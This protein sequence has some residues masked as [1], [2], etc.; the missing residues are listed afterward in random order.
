[1]QRRLFLC[2]LPYIYSSIS[3]ANDA[4]WNCEQSK[5]NKEWV[6]S[7]ADKPADS[8]PATTPE[9]VK[10]TATQPAAEPEQQAVEQASPT[11]QPITT[12][13]LPAAPAVVAKPIEP[14]PAQ[15]EAIPPAKPETAVAEPESAESELEE[16]APAVAGKSEPVPIKPASASSQTARSGWTCGSSDS[17][18]G[19]N[20]NLVG[21]DPAGKAQLVAAEPSTF[22]ILTPTFDHKQEQTF[23]TLVSQLQYDPWQNCTVSS[24][25]KPK[26]VPKKHLRETTPLDVKSDYSEVFDNEISS[27]FG[28]VEM[29]RADQH[30]ISNIANYDTVS[31]ALGLQ[32]SV[33]YSEDELAL[34][35]ESALLKLA[36]DQAKIRDVLFI[37][38]GVPL[39]GKA[40]AVY[41]ENKILSRYKDVAYTSCKPGNQDWLIHASELKMN[42]STGK[43]AAKN[44][45]LE[46][47]GAPVF[48]SPYL[49]FPIDDRRL[50]G[51]LAPSFGNT[52]RNGFDVSVPYYW[53]IAPNF[54]AT[55][56][57]RYLSKRGVLLGGEFRYLTEASKGRFGVE[58]MP[59]DTKKDNFSY[60]N[61]L[62]PHYDKARFVG[63]FVN[64]T[65]FN[66]NITSNIDANYRSDVDYFNDLGSALSRPYS[67]FLRSSADIGYRDAGISLVGRADS[68][69]SVDRAITGAALP[70]RR[71]PQINFN[72]NRA[73]DFMP[74]STALDTEYV[75]FQHNDRING[76]RFDVKPSVSFPMQTASAYLTPKL[77]VQHTQYMLSN[78]APGSGND[79]FLQ[80]GNT[81]IGYRTSDS[82]S[83]TLP[84]LSADAGVFLDRDLTIDNNSYTHSLEPR[85]FYLYIPKVNQDKIPVFDS[86]LYDFNFSSL[87]RENRFS[88]TDRIG[89]A[90]QV[91]A[92]LTSRLVDKKGRERVKM[93]V[94]NTFYLSDRDVTL[95]LLFPNY[96]AAKD[97]NGNYPPTLKFIPETNSFSNVVGELSSQV[98]DHISIDTGVQWSPYRNE[99]V[100]GQA[101]FHFVNQPGEIIN[102]GYRY[103]KN[104]L[105][106]DQDNA[107]LGRLNDIIQ[108]NVSFHWPIYDDWYAIGR[109]QYSLLYNSTQESFLGFEKENCCWRFR[110]IG[111]RWVNNISLLNA[112]NGATNPTLIASAQAESQTGI[113]FQVELK[114]LTGIGEKLDDFFEKQIYGYR[115]P[116]QD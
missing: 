39:R 62:N 3:Y 57:P 40:S 106:P 102:L 75:Y 64:F 71:L 97:K 115:K 56:K 5:D 114:G 113:F 11:Q 94:G 103:R 78:Q 33:Y 32:G 12:Q 9:P 23:N 13:P 41:R 74:L 116:E 99:I 80:P 22:R 43:G 27:Y 46:F 67:S 95:P 96:A 70:F 10:S 36:E 6:C 77:S 79:V 76:Q 45:W 53:N 65:Q 92:A 68:Y 60:D 69:Q 7:G 29:N 14:E 100:R 54:D 59:V 105:I 1:M 91:T 24:A 25:P 20:C 28:N 15:P 73:F 82:I 84:I 86:A 47:K 21:A 16:S 107:A 109:W 31:E 35:G 61:H 81:L 89:D 88:G 26:F 50:S 18:E 48:Y 83:R 112:L 104:T 111:R 49:S 42:K 30:S 4:A 38:P 101:D 72:F 66:P 52:Q 2:F 17:S 58:Y 55:L 93:S 85:L 90:N 110:I 98:T 37:S 19:W 44:A 108:T 8:V 34:Y 87:F 63:T 51:F